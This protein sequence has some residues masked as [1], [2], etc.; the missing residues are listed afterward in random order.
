[1]INASPINIVFIFMVVVYYGLKYYQFILYDVHVF[2]VKVIVAL[3][4]VG[5]VVAN[6]ELSTSM[7]NVQFLF[8]AE[9]KFLLIVNAPVV[10]QP[11]AFANVT[12]TFP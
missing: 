3:V 4:L 9:P 5:G 12:F 2:A 8:F 7:R 10:P 11:G 6:P 1:M